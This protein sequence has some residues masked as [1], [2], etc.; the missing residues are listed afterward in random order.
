MK[1]G[2][3]RLL[4]DGAD[5]YEILTQPPAIPGLVLECARYIVNRDELAADQQIA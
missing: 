3:E 1:E 5:G 4:R 2:I